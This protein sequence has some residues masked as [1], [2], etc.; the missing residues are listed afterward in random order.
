VTTARSVLHVLPHRGGGGETYVDHLARIDGYR[1][2][3]TFIAPG[4]SPS[5]VAFV[6]AL[7]AQSLAVR[8]NVLHVHGEVASGLCLPSIAL[9]PSVV[10]INGLHLV[11]RLAGWRRTAAE[12]NL[13]LIVRAASA[14]ICV[15]DAELAHVRGVVGDHDKLVLIPNGVDPSSIDENER[16]AVRAEFGLSP[17]D[18]VGV[19]VAGLDSH[20]EPLVAARAALEAARGV[21]RLVLVF[22]GDGPLRAELVALADTSPAIRVLGH[23]G[24]AHRVLAAADF[25]VLPSRREGLSFALL[26]AMSLGLPPV[27]SDEPANIE[28]VGDT[29]ITVPAGD[30]AGFAAAMRRLVSDESARRELGA[31]ARERVAEQFRADEMARRTAEIYD[32]L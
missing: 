3:K 7:R 1:F 22:A 11:R 17:S 29:G 25:F 6:G 31:L 5:P 4:P 15:S 2:D 14:T 21:T 24:D 19:V 30:I 9:R 12:H 20:K 26:E 8:H 32:A 23:R 10:T 13:R 28:A 27:V 16:D 18:V